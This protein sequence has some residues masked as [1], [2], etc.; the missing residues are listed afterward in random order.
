M[1]GTDFGTKAHA[2]KVRLELAARHTERML[3][4]GE[5][6]SSPLA[7]DHPPRQ[8]QPQAWMGFML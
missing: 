6:P 1:R 4:P 3:C 2:N 8:I 7:A 5:A